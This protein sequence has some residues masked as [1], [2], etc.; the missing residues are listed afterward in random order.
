VHSAATIMEQHYEYASH[1]MSSVPVAGI[2]VF[3]IRE[4][5][6]ILR[7]DSTLAEICVGTVNLLQRSVDLVNSEMLVIYDE[8]KYWREVSEASPLK[9][10]YTKLLKQGPLHFLTTARSLFE[11]EK[12]FEKEDSMIDLRLSILRETFQRLAILLGTLHNCGADI[13][14]I[15]ADYNKTKPNLVDDGIYDIVSEESFST[16]RVSPEHVF[17]FL[18]TSRLRISRCLNKMCSVFASPNDPPYIAAAS[19]TDN[20]D[21]ADCRSAADPSSQHQ[22]LNERHPPS[23]AEIV[24]MYENA[25]KAVS[26]VVVS[27]VQHYI[28]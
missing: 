28:H 26:E 23:T 3:M 9:K 12:I 18:Q 4:L 24:D 16:S 22:S 15:C 5:F 1:N 7:E 20:D 13:R 2:D 27:R 6:F 25:S 21:A 8:I 10:V 11:N 14:R 17:V 19:A